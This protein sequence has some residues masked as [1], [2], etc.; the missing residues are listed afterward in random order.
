[1]YQRIYTEN[2]CI[3]YV[4]MMLADTDPLG[5]SRTVDFSEIGGLDE[6]KSFVMMRTMNMFV[7]FSNRYSCT[8]GNG[9]ASITLSRVV[10]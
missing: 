5:V 7:N 2:I 4:D 6:R 3:F 9:H 10:Y 8:Q 1:M